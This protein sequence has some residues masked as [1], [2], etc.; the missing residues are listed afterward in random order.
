MNN[1]P[2]YCKLCK[3]YIAENPIYF[4]YSRIRFTLNPSTQ[5]PIGFVDVICNYHYIHF[6]IVVNQT[7]GTITVISKERYDS[8]AQLKD[9]L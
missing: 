3:E 5:T 7:Y 8:F 4:Y 9:I 1:K 2:P 6:P